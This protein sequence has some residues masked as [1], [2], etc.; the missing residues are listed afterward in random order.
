MC[1]KRRFTLFYARVVV[2]APVLAAW[3][4]VVRVVVVL[5]LRMRA[6]GT[7]FPLFESSFSFGLS[8][9]GLF[10]IFFT[11]LRVSLII[12]LLEILYFLVQL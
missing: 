4:A 10:I 1:H 7:S 8:L 3:L 12:Q 5:G 2:T 9:S 6:S 11:G